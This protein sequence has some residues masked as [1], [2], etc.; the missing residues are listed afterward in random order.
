MRFRYHLAASALAAGVAT[1][2]LA[3]GAWACIPQPLLSVEPQASGPAGSQLSVHAQT[4]PGMVSEIRWNSPVGPV[5]AT[6][7]DK[8]DF[9]LPVTIPDAPPGLYALIAVARFT[10]GSV[11]GT[12]RAAFL[13]TDPSG[14]AVPGTGAPAARERPAAPASSDSSGPPIGLVVVGAGL[15][16]LGGVG[17]AMVSR[18]RAQ[19]LP[20]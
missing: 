12:G 13:V 17:G 18:R 10:D 4:M 5:L 1:V 19:R 14:A 11:A 3:V 6:A 9:T 20:A 15:V 8:H 2:A 7:E 16:G